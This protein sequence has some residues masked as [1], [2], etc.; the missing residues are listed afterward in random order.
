VRFYPGVCIKISRRNWEV[1]VLETK[2]QVP[3]EL[4]WINPFIEP[5]WI[6]PF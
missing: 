5:I 4:I 3:I 1:R 2:T 6:N